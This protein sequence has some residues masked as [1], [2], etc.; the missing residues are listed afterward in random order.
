MCCIF[1]DKRELVIFPLHCCI[2]IYSMIQLYNVLHTAIGKR[3]KKLIIKKF[4]RTCAYLVLNDDSGSPSCL[5]T[6]FIPLAQNLVFSPLSWVAYELNSVWITN[7][8]NL[9]SHIID[10]ISIP[11]SILITLLLCLPVYGIILFKHIYCTSA[12]TFQRGNKFLVNL[13]TATIS[14]PSEIVAFYRWPPLLDQSIFLP[15]NLTIVFILQVVPTV[16]TD[17]SGHTIQS[18]QVQ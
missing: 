3:K 18:N 10:L 2:A 9:L 12:Y 11:Q 1:V 14:P 16:Y 7:I 6:Y 5:Y 17:V 13:F 15:R 4:F 8:N